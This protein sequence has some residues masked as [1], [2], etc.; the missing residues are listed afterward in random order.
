MEPTQI[1]HPGGNLEEGSSGR[2]WGPFIFNGIDRVENTIGYEMDN[3]V[4]SCF[5]CNRAK[6]VMPAQEFLELAERIY[7]NH[8]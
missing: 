7:L 6:N 5:K 1:H 8:A 4:T 3:V 2:S